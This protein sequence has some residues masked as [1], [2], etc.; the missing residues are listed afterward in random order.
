MLTC[1]LGIFL[2]GAFTV[3]TK[4]KD[5]SFNSKSLRS[6]VAIIYTRVLCPIGQW[7]T[8]KCGGKDDN[9]TP[10]SYLIRSYSIPIQTK[11]V[12]GR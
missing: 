5:Y 2:E 6:T 1:R 10:Y 4:V 7:V 12:D 8:C 9:L 11:S 3:I